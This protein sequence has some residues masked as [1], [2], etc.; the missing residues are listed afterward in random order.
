[1]MGCCR[2]VVHRYSSV[3]LDF[4]V[5]FDLCPGR[6]S[7]VSPA[8]SKVKGKVKPRMFTETEVHLLLIPK[9]ESNT[10]DLILH[11]A[12]GSFDLTL[13]FISNE[14]IKTL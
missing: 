13:Q 1:M 10:G 2:L 14:L 11:K 6:V 3:G 12:N 9:L 7:N 4:H 8:G 5:Y